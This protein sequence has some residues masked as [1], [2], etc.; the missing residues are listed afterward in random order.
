M[1]SPK[2]S[3]VSNLLSSATEN[4]GNERVRLST[5]FYKLSKKDNQCLLAYSVQ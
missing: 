4:V 5:N 1:D 3:C 2:V